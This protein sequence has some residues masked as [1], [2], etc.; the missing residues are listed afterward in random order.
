MARCPSYAIDSF[1][2][3]AD[4]TTIKLVPVQ[5]PPFRPSFAPQATLQFVDNMITTDSNNTI[6]FQGNVY[7]LYN[8]IQFCTGT[9]HIGA[10]TNAGGRGV[11]TTNGQPV[12][13]D[14]VLT[15]VN[16]A[17]TP[18]AII[19]VLPIY[20][21]TAPDSNLLSTLIQQKSTVDS[22]TSL[23]T[24]DMPSYGYNVCITTV[25]NAQ[26]WTINNGINAY[27]V[28]FP[29]GLSMPQADINQLKNLQAYVFHPANTH[30]IVTSFGFNSETDTYPPKTIDPTT[31]YCTVVFGNDERVSKH[32]TMYGKSPVHAQSKS[33]QSTLDQYKCYP[34]NELQNIKNDASGGTP[35][36][37]VIS[38]MEGNSPDSGFS[39]GIGI[40]LWILLSLTIIGTLFILISYFVTP[41]QVPV[42]ALEAA[43]PTTVT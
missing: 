5:Q 6:S 23:F 9:V 18:Q 22:L 43:A 34:L 16:R 13:A 27:V 8:D 28:S 10:G 35:I 25:E 14:L 37:K 20:P 41:N 29:S 33:A 19:V 31:F 15:F 32:V 17:Y 4:P 26:N 21:T 42:S 36:L 11:Y 30:P 2:H 12:A 3:I 39:S 24:D 1:L 38:A 40:I 7:S